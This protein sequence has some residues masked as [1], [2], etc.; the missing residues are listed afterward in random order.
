MKKTKENA[1]RIKAM[2]VGIAAVLCMSSVP[3]HAHATFKEHAS[4]NPIQ[5]KPSTTVRIVSE[6]EKASISRINSGVDA[7][8]LSAGNVNRDINKVVLAAPAAGAAA[9]AAQAKYAEFKP[10]IEGKAIRID[11]SP[12]R[13]ILADAEKTAR[14]Q[15]EAAKASYEAVLNEYSG[16]GSQSKS[17]SGKEVTI[18]LSTIKAK[19]VGIDECKDQ[20]KKATAETRNLVEKSDAFEKASDE[21]VEKRQEADQ[22]I[23]AGWG[24]YRELSG[25]MQDLSDS[26]AAAQAAPAEDAAE[27]EVAAGEAS[28]ALES[29]QAAYNQVHDP[30]N[31]PN[32]ERPQAQ[33]ALT[34]LTNAQENSACAQQKLSELQAYAQAG[35]PN[36]EVY[37]QL[38]DAVA[39]GLDQ[40]CPAVS[41]EL[42]MAQA[43]LQNSEIPLYNEVVDDEK[44]EIIKDAKEQLQ[45]MDAS[46]ADIEEVQKETDELIQKAE[47][48]IT[49]AD[50]S[51]AGRPADVT[52]PTVEPSVG[53]SSIG[54]DYQAQAGVAGV[55][56]DRQNTGVAG[57]R[58]EEKKDS[59]VKEEKKIEQQTI[60]KIKDNEIPLAELPADNH[61]EISILW[62]WIAMLA[63]AAAAGAGLTAFHHGKKISYKY[64]K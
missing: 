1:R 24:S 57:V 60:K 33:E 22:A 63:G 31:D 16:G 10:M 48:A 64:K 34:N 23:D 8:N 4:A 3:F 47:K 32:D 5:I 15:Y 42:E 35:S 38:S 18:D 51:P 62:L 28:G 41:R 14:E 43:D 40:D 36:A 46:L 13:A 2:A 52:D 56:T 45:E 58:K 53:Y 21:A 17:I 61:E 11:Q 19:T 7:V 37:G 12:A 25:N 39:S 44:K 50:N 26:V 27:A 6:T 54:Y 30:V 49:D 55:R 59:A 9:E 29:A 20:Y